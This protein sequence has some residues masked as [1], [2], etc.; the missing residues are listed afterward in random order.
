[1]AQKAV[2]LDRYRVPGGAAFFTLLSLSS[3]AHSREPLAEPDP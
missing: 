3:G 2:W 1:M